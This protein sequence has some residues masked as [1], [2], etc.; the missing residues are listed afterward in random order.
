MAAPS[1]GSPPVAAPIAAPAPAPSA[2]PLSTRCSVGDIP[3]QPSVAKVKIRSRTTLQYL[4]IFSLH[5]KRPGMFL[6]EGR[7]ARSLG[8]VILYPLVV[9]SQSLNIYNLFPL[10]L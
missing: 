10:N 9:P 7:H 4:C 8:F 2:P 3:A 1:A 6:T 5:P